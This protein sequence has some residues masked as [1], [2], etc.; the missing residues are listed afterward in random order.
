MRRLM[1]LLALTT[2]AVLITEAW[3]HR[4]TDPLLVAAV[5][6]GVVVLVYALISASGAVEIVRHPL[7]GRVDPDHVTR[8]GPD[9]TERR[10]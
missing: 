2:Q 1:N 9:N 5:S 10:P 8:V 7:G 4:H 3:R 6:L